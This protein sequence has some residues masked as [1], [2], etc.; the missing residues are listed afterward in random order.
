MIGDMDPIEEGS[1]VWKRLEHMGYLSELDVGPD[2]AAPAAL[3][4][5]FARFQ[6]DH[7]LNVTG[8]L[9]DATKAALA[10]LHGS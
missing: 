7:G 3:Y 1:G 4:K 9:D 2:G 8:V 10:R 6:A 5:A